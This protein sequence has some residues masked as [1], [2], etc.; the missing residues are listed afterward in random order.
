MYVAIWTALKNSVFT[1][2]RVHAFVWLQCW[3]AMDSYFMGGLQI[4][5]GMLLSLSKNKYAMSRCRHRLYYTIYGA[6]VFGAAIL[7]TRRPGLHL[8]LPWQPEAMA[9]DCLSSTCD[10]IEQNVSCIGFT[11]LVVDLCTCICVKAEIV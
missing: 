4:S 5:M 10:P 2:Q 1:R 9:A 8:F 11:A 6:A 7:V 3:I